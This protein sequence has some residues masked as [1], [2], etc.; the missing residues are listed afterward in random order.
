[1]NSEAA[2][3]SLAIVLAVGAMTFYA[4]VSKHRLSVPWLSPA[5]S[6]PADDSAKQAAIAECIKTR[7]AAM[8][9]AENKRIEDDCNTLAGLWSGYPSKPETKPAPSPGGVK[10]TPEGRIQVV[11]REECLANLEADNKRSP[12]GLDPAYMKR[13]QERCNALYSSDDSRLK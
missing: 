1:M 12:H 13:E 11:G 4:D 10:V 2:F 5:Q 9:S 7:K 6:K 8:P 3:K